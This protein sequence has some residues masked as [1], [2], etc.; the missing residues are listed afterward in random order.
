VIHSFLRSWALALGIVA[1][2][3]ITA[4][5]HIGV[6]SISG[7]GAGF[8]H[9]FTG[10][11]HLLAMVAIGLWAA[12]LGGR[13]RWVVPATFVIVMAAGGAL[14][15]LGVPIPGIEQGILVSLLVLGLLIA[16][17]LRLP[18]EAGV[19][20]AAVFAVF[21]GHAHGTEM[22]PEF[23]GLAYGAGFAIASAVLHAAG[24][25]MGFVFD[26]MNVRIAARIAGAFIAASGI[27]LAIA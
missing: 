23:G 26:K 25:G 4:F 8:L 19:L 15:M 21:H 13:A 14:G 22:S 16:A 24:V 1:L 7:L 27:Y 18:T 12:Q 17:S 6:G 20:I 10:I 2:A 3:P 9:P 5:A 11:D